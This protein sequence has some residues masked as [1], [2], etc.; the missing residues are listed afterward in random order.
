MSDYTTSWNKQELS[1]YV[2]LY[3]AN[4]NFSKAEEETD[5][6]R[7]KV[8]PDRYKSIHKEFNNDNDYQSISKIKV[9]VDRLGYSEAQIDGLID[10]I[11]TLFL[12]DG[13]F[14]QSEKTLFFGLKKLLE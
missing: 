2:L 5:M 8:D 1:A 13:T 7:S 4:A 10:E 3:C 14:D 9:A 11:K 6:I 12:A